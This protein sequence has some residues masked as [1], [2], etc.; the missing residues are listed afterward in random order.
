MAQSAPDAQDASESFP[1]HLC[2]PHSLLLAFGLCLA[3][4][5]LA[6]YVSYAARAADLKERTLLLLDSVRIGLNEE[7]RQTQIWAERAAELLTGTTLSGPLVD[8]Y[9][10]LWPNVRLS[11]YD[12]S[13]NL[14]GQKSR[15]PSPPEEP[16]GGKS[17][18][19]RR[20]ATGAA[21][22]AFINVNAEIRLIAAARTA[23]DDAHIVLVSHP[24]SPDMLSRIK[25][26]IGADIAVLAPDLFENFHQV[27]TFSGID[28]SPET[29]QQFLSSRSGP[30]FADIPLG[31]RLRPA[32]ITRLDG[33]EGTDT[34]ILVVAPQKEKA[35]A[36]PDPAS[37]TVAATAAFCLFL[38][39][40]YAGYRR[41]KRTGKSLASDLKRFILRG[42]VDAGTSLPVS[43]YATLRE[44]RADLAAA[45]A[46]AGK[47]LEE[48]NEARRMLE[49]NADAPARQDGGGFRTFFEDAQTGFFLMRADGD[50]LQVNQSFALLL[51]Y[52][53][54]AHITSE[55]TSLPD[56]FSNREEAGS[57]LS[58]MQEFP[59]R[60][61]AVT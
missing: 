26:Q 30:V 14:L 41:E 60:S 16:S 43:L 57:F 56:L 24:L 61:L 4:V 34:T 58:L 19:I 18:L 5:G 44:I 47:A 7:L 54:P 28:A 36:D 29:L 10:L 11:F 42:T 31:G 46:L 17:G 3:A 1:R 38:L 21:A 32:G 13:G 40:S 9:S 25:S 49:K 59:G 6:L 23:D 39:L 20:A 53:S 37:L 33:T 27:G 35:A 50:L 45:R 48:R 22:A 8:A 51:G 52:E 15:A 2:A 12:Q 55:K